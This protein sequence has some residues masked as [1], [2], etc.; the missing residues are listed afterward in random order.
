MYSLIISN[1]G[2]DV[3]QVSSSQ[4]KLEAIALT[5]IANGIKQIPEFGSLEIHKI[6]KECLK[7]KD[8]FS[9][10]ELFCEISDANY[11]MVYMRIVPATL[12]LD[13]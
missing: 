11:N 3:V 12:I 1:Q 13:A 6:L 9:A 5:T 10:M 4:Q 8:A 7:V 2:G